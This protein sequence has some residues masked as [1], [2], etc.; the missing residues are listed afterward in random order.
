M[1][2]SIG[3]EAPAETAMAEKVTGL[4]SGLMEKGDVLEKLLKTAP[5]NTAASAS[6]YAETVIPAMGEVRA[7]AD[8]LELS[9]GK[10]YW[11]FPTYG[12]L[13]FYV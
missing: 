1:K 2:K 3:I 7:L 8:E 6:Y 5:D 13:L 12:D 4:I 10:D 11:P 9:V